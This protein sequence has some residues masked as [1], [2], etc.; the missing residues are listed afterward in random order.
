MVLGDGCSLMFAAL[1]LTSHASVHDAHADQEDY[2]WNMLM[3]K[4]TWKPG[5]VAEATTSLPIR[6]MPCEGPGKILR[7]IPGYTWAKV[8]RLLWQ[9]NSD[10]NE[11]LLVLA[12]IQKDE[13]DDCVLG[14]V[15]SSTFLLPYTMPKLRNSVRTLSGDL[16]L[17]LLN[18]TFFETLTSGFPIFGIYDD[19]STA[20]YRSWFQS[21]ESAKYFDPLPELA[22]CGSPGSLVLKE[23]LQDQRDAWHAANQTKGSKGP[24]LPGIY[25][26]T[27][28]SISGFLDAIEV[29]DAS[30]ECRPAA[31]AA[32]LVLALTRAK[33][34]A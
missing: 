16:N 9:S 26:D 5:H 11:V 21:S 27:D 30:G 6:D 13:P 7:S 14:I 18:V 34:G 10:R 4:D 24:E 1:L 12:K 23:K 15:T 28:R 17:F 8:K 25:G 32:T 19:L 3:Q 2:T 22:V 33:A 20:T 31:A 29:L